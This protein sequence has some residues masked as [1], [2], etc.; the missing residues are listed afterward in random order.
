[1]ATMSF[2][3]DP[4]NDLIDRLT[5]FSRNKSQKLFA[6]TEL[7]LYEEAGPIWIPGNAELQKAISDAPEQWPGVILESVVD[8]AVLL[9][10]LRHILLTHFDNGRRRA[11]LRYWSPR[12]ASYFFEAGTPA[13]RL[14]WLGPIS[15]IRWFGGT[16]R[17]FAEG[18][19]GWKEQHNPLA[20][21][22]T[23]PMQSSSLPLLAVQEEA[24]QRQECEHFVQG[25][26]ATQPFGSFS[27]SWE[28]FTDGLTAGFDQKAQLLSYMSQRVAHTAA[29]TPPVLPDGRPE[30][31]LTILRNHLQQEARA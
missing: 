25:W 10:H 1:M 4:H 2:L 30:E 13:D 12:T 22:W 16:W 3:L 23:A 20:L 5:Q 27:Q 15:C 18:H 28:Y 26:H 9:R 7:S 24:L 19:Q 31:H 17:E 6:G 21:N 14:P 11:V 29:E 8:E